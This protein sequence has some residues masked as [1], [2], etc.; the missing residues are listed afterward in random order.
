MIAV[1][2]SS[3]SKK[4]VSE[5]TKESTKVELKDTTVH[6]KVFLEPKKIEKDTNISKGV[7]LVFLP[8]QEKQIVVTKEDKKK[9]IKMQT[10]ID[11][12]GNMYMD[13]ETAADSLEYEITFQKEKVTTLRETV[14]EYEKQ[15]NFFRK[16]IRWGS[17]II[18]TVVI[19]AIGLAILAYRFKKNVL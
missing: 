11:S 5:S 14:K 6:G 7:K 1:S 19:V 8:G 17:I 16:I 15:E 4:L 3:C 12:L 2:L 10:R 9:G 13:C 18:A